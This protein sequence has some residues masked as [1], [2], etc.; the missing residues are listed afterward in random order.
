VVARQHRQWRPLLS[1]GGRTI[2]VD[3]DPAGTAAA[4]VAETF[5]ARGDVGGV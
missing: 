2:I 1:L 4:A 3:I 5:G